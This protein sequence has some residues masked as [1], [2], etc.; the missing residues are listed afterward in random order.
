[1]RDLTEV[2]RQANEADSVVA[3]SPDFERIVG[4]HINAA[5]QFYLADQSQMAATTSEIWVMRDRLGNYLLS[6]EPDV[7]RLTQQRLSALS[8]VLDDVVSKHGL[9]PRVSVKC[10]PSAR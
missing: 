4:D 5:F 2:L 7:G 9:S 8:S 6:G 3:Q 10:M 1:M